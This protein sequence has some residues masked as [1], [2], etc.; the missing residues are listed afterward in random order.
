MKSEKAALLVYQMFD[1]FP[2]QITLE[3]S[4]F[5]TPHHTITGVHL[6]LNAMI[7]DSFAR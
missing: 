7:V 3:S 5:Q 6:N 2:E 1:K 4:A